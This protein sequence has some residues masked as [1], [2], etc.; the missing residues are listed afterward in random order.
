[1]VETGA[2]EVGKHYLLRNLPYL[3]LLQS[4][5]MLYDMVLQEQSGF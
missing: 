1:M 2:A 3:R 4:Q 5:Q